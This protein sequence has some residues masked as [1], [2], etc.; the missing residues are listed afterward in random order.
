MNVKAAYFEAT[1]ITNRKYLKNILDFKDSYGFIF[2]TSRNEVD[3]DGECI[4]VNKEDPTDIV[5]IP[6][7]FE[8]LNFLESGKKLPLSVIK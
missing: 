2:G 4:V 6:I 5:T 3:L 1:K 8:N 7:I